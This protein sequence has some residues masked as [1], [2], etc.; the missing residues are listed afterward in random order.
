MDL[1]SDQGNTAPN[2]NQINAISSILDRGPAAKDPDQD[3]QGKQ[4]LKPG[5]QQVGDDDKTL[6][7][8]DADK[9]A[10]VQKTLD[11]KGPEPISGDDPTDSKVTLKE[12]A[13]SMDLDAK[14]LYDVEITIG[15]DHDQEPITATLGELKDGFKELEKFR[16]DAEQFTA[17]KVEQE[18]QVMTAKRQ[19]DQLVEL[20]A[21]TNSLHPEV[22][23]RL[24]II[25][26]QTVQTE[27]RAVLA[28]IP[29]WGNAIERQKDFTQMHG[30]M[31]EYGFSEWEVDNE[32]DH[33]KLKLMRD[34]AALKNQIKN[35]TPKPSDKVP[36][37]TGKGKRPASKP[38]KLRERV[39]AAKSRSASKQ[40]KVGVISELIGEK[41]N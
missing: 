35:A 8:G 7:G 21:K 36:A 34:F 14:D 24:E 20:G 22:L 29:E 38:S 30:A 37:N 40:Q 32:I 26:G 4:A 23:A 1:D 3:D 6:K 31:A 12:L 2:Q 13:A 41:F 5:Q 39:S 33:R 10:D 25:H 28:A 19:I 17:R 11:G 15:K 18:N 16:G 27:L 9:L